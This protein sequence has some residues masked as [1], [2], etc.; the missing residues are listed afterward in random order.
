MA[1][2][3]QRLAKMDKWLA[4]TNATTAEMQN[5]KFE[6]LIEHMNIQHGIAYRKMVVGI[7]S[8]IDTYLD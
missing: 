6:R 4:G 2:L 8:V 3:G 1:S 5:G 7:D